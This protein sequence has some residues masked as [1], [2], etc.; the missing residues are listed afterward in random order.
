MFYCL[1]ITNV[2]KEKKTYKKY[3]EEKKK[4]L[5]TLMIIILDQK[6]KL[7]LFGLL[8]LLTTMI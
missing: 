6:F 4:I 7:S 2:L 8:F 5:K 3:F 1:L